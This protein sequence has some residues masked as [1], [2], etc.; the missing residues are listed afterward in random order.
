MQLPP[1][2]ELVGFFE[3]EPRLAAPSTPWEYNSITFECQ[4]GGDEIR[5]HLE[6]D[7]GELRFT[8]SSEGVSRV[9]LKVG[10]LESLAVHLGKGDEHL[11]AAAGGGNPQQILKI[12]LKPFVSVEWSSIHDLR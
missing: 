9:S 2:H 12:R 7:V 4:R 6:P 1:D 10:G 3:C 5:C 8:W 11:I